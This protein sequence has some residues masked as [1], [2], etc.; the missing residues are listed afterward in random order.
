MPHPL[1]NYVR[2]FNTQATTPSSAILESKL[3]LSYA[4]TLEWTP[5]LV[6]TLVLD[7]RMPVKSSDT[8]A[9][10]SLPLS[11]LLL[12]CASGFAARVIS[13]MQP[14]PSAE[15]EMIVF[16]METIAP[17]MCLFPLVLP[18]ASISLGSIDSGNGDIPAADALWMLRDASLAAKESSLGFGEEVSIGSDTA[19][20]DPFILLPPY[21]MHSDDAPIIPM[22]SC[23]AFH[24]STVEMLPPATGPPCRLVSDNYGES[25]LP[26]DYG[27]CLPAIIK[28]HSKDLDNDGEITAKLLSTITTDEPIT[29]AALLPTFKPGDSFED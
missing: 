28:V 22:D 11:L 8:Q 2:V 7:D 15:E 23:F 1:P 27:E 14:A 4:V 19:P 20:S 5:E 18:M 29:T 16:E 25:Q 12:C 17:K 24:H 13:L 6:P 26:V 3:K 9:G 21:K 10:P